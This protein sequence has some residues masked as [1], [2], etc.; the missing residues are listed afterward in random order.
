MGYDDGTGG[1][2]DDI[3]DIGGIGLNPQASADDGGYDGGYASGG[4]DDL[5]QPSSAGGYDDNAGVGPVP[6][7]AIDQADADQA[8]DRSI[9]QRY[10]DQ[11]NLIAGA[12]DLGKAERTAEL[13]AMGMFD[14]E[15][16]GM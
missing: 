15:I 4:A 2:G 12:D 8:F 13:G 7:E 10:Q 6:Q 3:A 16:P 1:G 14:Q 9:D 5:M 11:L